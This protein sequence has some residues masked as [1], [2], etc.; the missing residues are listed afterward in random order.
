MND[1]GITQE[2]GYSDIAVKRASATYF[3][4][5]RRNYVKQGSKRGK[6]NKENSTGASASY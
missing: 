1:S 4:T 5:M 3:R 6:V 2:T